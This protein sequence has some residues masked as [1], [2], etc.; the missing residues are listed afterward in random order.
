L[1]TVL[2]TGFHPDE[3]SAI[4]EYLSCI[5]D[6]D[7]DPTV[8]WRVSPAPD[9]EAA[10]VD[11][12]AG[13]VVVVEAG[14]SGSNEKPTDKPAS[15]QPPSSLGR[16]AYLVAPPGSDTALYPA[17]LTAA[18][19]DL[20]LWPAVTGG[21]VRSHHG[22][23]LGDALAAVRAAHARHHGLDLPLLTAADVGEAAAALP[24]GA[25]VT[26][27]ALLDAARPPAWWDGEAG[28][29]AG[30]QG[31][32]EEE[33]DASALVVLDG[34]L[35]PFE[36]ADLLDA[37]TEAGW[38]HASGPPPAKWDRATADRAGDAPTW[39]AR[40]DLLD[41]LLTH[42]PPA[43]A[44]LQARLAALYSSDYA[45]FFSPG[46]A[47]DPGLTPLVANAVTAGDPAAYHLDADPACLNPE[48]P[49]AALHGLHPNRTPGAPLLASAIVYL[50]DWDV[51]AHNGETLF[52]DEGS[53]LG[54]SCAP[55]AGRV[56]LME[57]DLAHRISPPSASAGGTPRYSL[58]LKLVLH[59]VGRGEGGGDAASRPNSLIKREWGPPL[60]LG[61]ASAT[62]PVPLA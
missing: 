46:E 62:G 20:G 35:T 16:V 48:G 25:A 32:E 9:L 8:P 12:D 55:R 23:R 15:F 49:W 17:A 11:V 22:R 43:F 39:G 3:I 42:P 59:P 51:A 26:L 24:P 36:A 2:L 4:N 44:A 37:L 50:Q 41:S 38:D 27:H 14:G 6:E 40:P 10:T 60:R 54:L 57:G 19:G 31:E 33:E 1:A 56:V 7:G 47:C 34:L 58:V 13:A 18:L 5:E 53:G 61:T 29:T 52:L 45:L 30:A 21:G 28:W